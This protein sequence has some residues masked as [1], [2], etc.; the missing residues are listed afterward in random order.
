MALIVKSGQATSDKS[1][2]RE[3]KD[4]E[5][6]WASVKKLNSTIDKLNKYHFL[7]DDTFHKTLAESVAAKEEVATTYEMLNASDNGVNEGINKAST[8]IDLLY[9]N[10]SKEA[11][12]MKSGENLT[13]QEKEQL[14]K[15]KTKF[16]LEELNKMRNS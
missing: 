5:P 15:L 4:A 6:F 14:A 16:L 3:N 8:A 2:K 12:R 7:K 1:L 13:S 10:Y 11:L 9:E